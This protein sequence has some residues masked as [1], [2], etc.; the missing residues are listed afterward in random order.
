[1]CKDL[2]RSDTVRVINKLSSPKGYLVGWLRYTTFQYT[3]QPLLMVLPLPLGFASTYS[4]HSL[5]FMVAWSE[6]S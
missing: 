6:I 3:A 1:M 2:Q 5:A 4:S